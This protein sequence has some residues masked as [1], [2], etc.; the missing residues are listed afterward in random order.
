MGKEIIIYANMSNGLVYPHDEVCYFQS[1]VAHH[2]ESG[3]FRIDSLPYSGVIQLLQGNKI[4]IVD[5][6]RHDKPFSDAL[7]F[8]VPS[9]CLVFNRA[10]G[11]NGTKVCEW[12]TREMV[13][14]THRHVHKPLVQAIRKLVK[15]YGH[16]GPAIIGENVLL[17][18]HKQ[19]NFDGQPEKIR[20][21]LEL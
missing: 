9:F 4:Q 12:Q 18:C 15:I 17:T 13:Y 8:G 5:A 11:G 16:K 6:T 10:I 19:V 7:K 2:W 21:R 20:E 3:Y 14:A 1:N